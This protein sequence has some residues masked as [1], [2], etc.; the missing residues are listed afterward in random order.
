M[1]CLI[2]LPTI[3]ILNSTMLSQQYAAAPYDAIEMMQLPYAITTMHTNCYYTLYDIDLNVDH[4]ICA[5][6]DEQDAPNR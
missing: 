1:R 4:A 6:D 3:A 5:L 2:K